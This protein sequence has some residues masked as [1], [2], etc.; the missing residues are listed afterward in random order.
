M[1]NPE[2][3]PEPESTPRP[4]LRLW[5]PILL[6]VAYWGIVETSY[7][8]EMAM[9]HRF[10]TRL[11]TLMGVLILFFVWGMSRRHFRW[12]ERFA[13]FGIFL[14]CWIVGGLLGDKTN[15][16][17][18]ALLTAG[19]IALTLGTAWLWLSK[20]QSVNRQI[21]GVAASALV[22]FGGNSLLRWD[23]MDGR[24]QA[25][26]SWRWT[27]TAEDQFLKTVTTSTSEVEKP[28]PP[29]KA[30]P[31]DWTSFRGGERENILKGIKLADWTNAPPKELW[32]HRIGPGWSSV[33]AVD[34]YLF[35]QEQRGPDEAVV[36]YRAEDGTE[37]WQ[38]S[39]PNRFE[40][41]LSGT[42]PRGTPSFAEGKLY[43]IG[44]TGHCICLD[45]S[46]G[47]KVWSQNI[48]EESGG[49]VPEWGSATSPLVVDQ[50]VV[51]FAG[52]KEDR[53]L[54][55]F[56]RIDG[57]PVWNT[58]TGTTTYATP[59]VMTLGGLRQIVMHDEVGLIG[60]RIEDGK[61][62]WKHPSP[63]SGSFQPMLQPHGIGTDEMIVGWDAGLLRLKI[64]REGENWSTSEI[65]TSNRL[66][67]SFDEYVIHKEHL[68]GMDDG[69]LCCIDIAKGGRKWKGGRYGFGQ[70][71]LLPDA[72]ELLILSEQGEV[73]RVAAQPE[74]HREIARVKAIEGKTWNH[75]LLVSDRLIVRNSEEIACL[76]VKTE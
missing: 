46:T 1:S 74:K 17:F 68:Y 73:V 18:P 45:A 39:V 64:N 38:H 29:L 35:T 33:I 42:G 28:L 60:V 43:A 75:L 25:S 27:P 71:L 41:A 47:K 6:L 30:T 23:G 19:P 76:Q 21:A 66:K 58:A 22:A 31:E 11:L 4:K 15:G 48:I 70:L 49:V 14:T 34:G 9:F 69:I 5:F 24:Q 8:I 65:W 54:L 59:Q 53:G 36:C 7:Q 40:Q 56:D 51:V 2:V 37:I 3:P 13:I 12:R 10:L 20:N 72:D 57:Q 26:F 52:G 67:P 44:A 50:L 62:L 61:Q 55:A 63:Y 32:K 16:L